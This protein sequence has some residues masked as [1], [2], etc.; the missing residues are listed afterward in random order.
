MNPEVSELARQTLDSIDKKIDAKLNP[1]AS[2]M[3][4]L[5]QKM[6]RRGGGGTEFETKSLG[7]LVAENDGLKA[8]AEDI[9]RRPGT[10]PME[11]KA[12]TTATG[13]GAAAVAQPFR[14]APVSQPRRALT[15]R[16]LLNAITI[17][18]GSVEVPRQSGRTNNAGMV[19]EGTLKP[20]SDLTWEM[21]TVPARKIAHW[22]IASSEI[23]ADAPQ[24]AGIIDTELVY[25]LDYVEDVQLLKGDGTGQNLTGLIPA[26]TAYALPAGMTDFASPT[27]IDKVALA[28]LQ[29]ALANYTPDGV[30]LHPA[31]WLRMRL[32]KNAQG[33]YILGDPGRGGRASP[34]RRS[35]GSDAGHER[36]PV[37]DWPVRRRGNDL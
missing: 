3:A 33:D 30:V 34:V 23:L 16:S 27:I 21:L 32:A 31:D 18:T 15:V 13:S 6:A 36:R 37:P 9:D 7:A 12:I 19:A 22:V 25:G 8:F 10:F 35:R 2:A 20:Q 26:A 1:V 28:M 14:D 5:E 29:A 4:D 24:L 17:S 11:T